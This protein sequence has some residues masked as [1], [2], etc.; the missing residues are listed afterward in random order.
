VLASSRRC[1]PRSMALRAGCVGHTAE[2]AVRLSRCVSGRIGMGG[3][4]GGGR[5]S[6]IP[7]G[8]SG[9]LSRIR[10]LSPGRT[11]R[12]GPG[13]PPLCLTLPV[14]QGPT[15]ARGSSGSRRT[16]SGSRCGGWGSCAPTRRRSTPC[17]STARSDTRTAWSV[18]ARWEG[19]NDQEFFRRPSSVPPA[20]A[21]RLPR[22][23]SATPIAVGPA[24]IRPILP[25]GSGGAG[26]AAGQ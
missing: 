21:R 15:P 26:L 17:G 8:R 10:R 5:F 22:R 3:D 6:G 16:G 25:L 9:L 11:R 2:R 20:S 24:P 7:I 13:S 12:S 23:R 4:S 19:R 14:E 1:P 18:S